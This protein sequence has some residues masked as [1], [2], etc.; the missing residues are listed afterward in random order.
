MEGSTGIFG[1]RWNRAPL[2]KRKPVY[3]V[4]DTGMTGV[5]AHAGSERGCVQHQ[6]KF[7]KRKN[8]LDDSE[9]IDKPLVPMRAPRQRAQR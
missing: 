5:V 3:R 1:G 6:V 2:T 9:P 4:H 8:R 7:K